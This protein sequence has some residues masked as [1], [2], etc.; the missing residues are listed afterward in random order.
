MPLTKEKMIAGLKT[1]D[2]KTRPLNQAPSV[3]SSF[4]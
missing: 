1:S 2:I 3:R 4:S